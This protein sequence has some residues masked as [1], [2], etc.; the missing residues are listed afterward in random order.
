MKVNAVIAVIA[1][2][3]QGG[4]AG[5]LF[6]GIAFLLNEDT[7]RLRG[8][9][10]N[11]PWSPVMP[12]ILSKP[13]SGHH[14]S[15][16]P[17]LLLTLAC[18]SSA[19]AAPLPAF[20]MASVDIGSQLIGIINHD[21]GAV[22]LPFVSETNSATGSTPNGST[23][24]ASGNASADEFGNLKVSATAA[25]TTLPP[26]FPAVSVVIGAVAERADAFH[27][28][29]APGKS[30]SFLATLE[31]SGPSFAQC[32][33]D[34]CIV[35]ITDGLTGAPAMPSASYYYDSG[36]PHNNV[37]PPAGMRSQAVW[38]FDAPVQFEITEVL[39]V[40]INVRGRPSASF[41]ADFSHTG[42]FY[43]DPITP[44]ATYT[45]A[46]GNF[47]FSPNVPGVPEPAT[48]TMLLALVPVF[49]FAARR[50]LA[51]RH[52]GDTPA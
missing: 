5:G 25:A 8:R 3:A 26:D 23:V 47:Y 7:R 39:L 21:S 22:A 18:V 27:F 37:P 20:V 28:L 52:S 9:L 45:T 38:T 4:V 15:P 1:V 36:D 31:W 46:S 43:L 32:P 13:A 35:N 12:T 33:A 50:K 16:V 49:A 29:P 30:I 17:A 41:S 19:H 42:H 6:R 51:C 34:S 2:I 10:A 40:G 14:P 24:S 44:G 11:Q 48:A